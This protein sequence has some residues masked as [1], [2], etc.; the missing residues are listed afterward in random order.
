[1]AILDAEEVLAD[2]DR[3]LSGFLAGREIGIGRNDW[4][5]NTAKE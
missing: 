1:M 3:L 4:P 2:A 5:L